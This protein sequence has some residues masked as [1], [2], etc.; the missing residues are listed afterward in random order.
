MG[1]VSTAGGAQ[2]QVQRL[3]VVSPATLN[4]KPNA[5]LRQVRRRSTP[6]LTPVCGKSGDAQHQA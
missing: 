2:R 1:G 4:A 3:S 5:R 6:S